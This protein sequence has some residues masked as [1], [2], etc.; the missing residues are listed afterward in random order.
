MVCPRCI[1]V[2]SKILR[3]AGLQ[4]Q[5]VELG[6]AELINAEFIKGNLLAELLALEGFE[7]IQER[8]DLLVSQVKTL[9]LEYLGLENP[10]RLSD[11][12]A[13]RTNTSYT[14]LSKIF[15][16]A[17]QITIEKYFIR[18]KIEKVK[19]LLSYDELNL[20]EIAHHLHYSSVQ[21]LS[22]QFKTVT[23][24]TV[25]DFKESTHQSRQSLDSL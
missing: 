2:V 18:L 23:G 14:H 17:S 8:Q 7:L 12:L 25:S 24:Y 6:K 10:P 3:D 9:F 19:E 20:S 11:F 5:S 13:D 22:L 4:V 1:S 15:S 21:A 16:T